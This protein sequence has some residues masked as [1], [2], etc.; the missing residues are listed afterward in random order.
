MTQVPDWVAPPR[1]GWRD[2][3]SGG[4]A[5]RRWFL[6]WV[7]EAPIDGLQWLAFHAFSL[8]PVPVASAFGGLLARVLTPLRH[9]GAAARARANLRWLRPD[10]DAAEIRARVAR[11]YEDLGRLLAEGPVLHRLMPEGRISIEGADF[12]ARALAEGQTFV[13]GTHTANWEVIAPVVRRL[14]V[15][16]LDVFEPQPSRTQT[17]LALAVRRRNAPAGTG[18]VATGRQAARAVARWTKAGRPALLFCDEAVGGTSIVPFFGRPPHLRSNYRFLLRMAKRARAS[19]VVFHV[20]R[21]PGCR[22]TV[23]FQ[24]PLKPSADASRLIEDAVALDAV[25]AGP[26]RARPEQWYWLGWKFEG[27]DEAEQDR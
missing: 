21:H 24:P 6:H 17:R 10:L 18:F 19:L 20:E 7:V 2:L 4:E 5:R 12:L 23:R 15:V 13:V 1:P 16:L 27:V 11:H 25:I 14:G 8:L 26:I 22:F 9:P 3:A